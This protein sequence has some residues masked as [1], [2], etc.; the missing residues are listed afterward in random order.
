LLHNDLLTLQIENFQSHEK[1]IVKFAPGGQLT[2]VTGCTDS[3][4][5]A[6]FR[7]LRWLLYNQPQ[8]TDF[9]RGGCTFVRVSGEFA[10]GHT[11]IR[12]R[13][14]SKNQYRIVAPGAGSPFV[15]EGFGNSV[16]FEVQEIT[17]IR[18]VTIGDMD[19]NLNMA[20][21]LDGPFLGKSISSGTRAKVMGKLAGT[22]VLDFAG[23]TV[24]TDLFRRNQDEKRLTREVNGLQRA[25]AEYDYLPA[26][27][28]KIE[29]IDRLVETVKTNK[30][31][32]DRLY[33]IKVQIES[34]D[35]LITGCREI[36][37]RW[38]FVD[39]AA[40][41]AAEIAEKAAKAASIE[42]LGRQLN[43]VENAIAGAEA[44]I[45]R[46]KN[47][48]TAGKVA[49][50]A[51]GQIQ[52]TDVFLGVKN[53]LTA[54]DVVVAQCQAIINRFKNVEQADQIIVQVNDRQRRLNQILNLGQNINLVELN[55]KRANGV[56]EK[57][58][59]IDKVEN[60][61]SQITDK[62]SRFEKLSVLWS[63]KMLCKAGL[64]KA[65]ET[66]AK[67]SGVNVADVIRSGLEVAT[68]NRRDTLF[69]L[70][71][72]SIALDRSIDDLK[73][74]VIVH[75]QRVTQLEGVYK[76]ELVSCKICPLCGQTI[77]NR[78]VA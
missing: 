61:V 41:M 44:T 31:R 75:E 64:Q 3:G 23:K 6:I 65:N 16:P 43:G 10:S 59:W 71:A 53:R 8:G 69:K 14:A 22:E 17:G 58:T 27:A 54:F 5:T 1:T 51:A 50:E 67:L 70:K 19:F 76:D 36:I 35:G 60:I 12:E 42:Q 40:G 46:F 33:L 9:I 47:V 28:A 4:K 49:A 15:L 13:T 55:I 25:V 73:G 52:R 30:A 38:Q 68:I 11:I 48:D 57:L 56:I 34:K 77:Q 66:L 63:S 32:W 21:Q 62:I 26:L 24:G 18:T 72:V 7:A 39:V 74:S 78:Q 20:E 2:V 37:T 45:D 29:T